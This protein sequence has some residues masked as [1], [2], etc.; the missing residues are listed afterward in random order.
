MEAFVVGDQVNFVSA[1]FL[2][3]NRESL[4]L[5]W[6]SAIRKISVGL[7]HLVP[8]AYEDTRCTRRLQFPWS[9]RW[10]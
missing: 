8:Y 3:P 9:F 4:H 2:D 10:V 1:I 5:F 7:I 6:V